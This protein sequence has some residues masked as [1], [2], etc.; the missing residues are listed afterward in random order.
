MN[1]KVYPDY[2]SLQEEFKEEARRIKKFKLKLISV[3]ISLI[4]IAT[5]LLFVLYMTNR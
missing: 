5:G 3:G 4:L 2:E 1:M